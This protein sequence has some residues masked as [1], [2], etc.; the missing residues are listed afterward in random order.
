M[1]LSDKKQTILY[2]EDNCMIQMAMIS[3]IDRD[4][5]D[6]LIADN[7]SQALNYIFDDKLS[8]DV[9]LTDVDLGEGANGWEVARCAR[10]QKPD[11]P[12]IYTSSVDEAAWQ[13]NG[14]SASKLCRKPFRPSHV[15][16]AISALLAVPAESVFVPTIAPSPFVAR[17]R[18]AM[19]GACA[20]AVP[21]AVPALIAADRA[22]ADEG[23]RA[24][25]APWV[26]GPLGQKLFRK[27][28]PAPNG[29]WTAQRKAEVVAAV[30]GGLLSPDEL[31]DL[32]GLS[33]EEFASW[34]RAIGRFG[35]SALKQTR[36]QHYRELEQRT[37]RFGWAG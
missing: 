23:T 14:V 25:G 21:A 9:L 2:V 17:Y 34:Q 12:V 5:F 3:F 20:V 35:L 11:M 6:I 28:L 4:E 37:Q 32:Y 36:T 26:V 27:A 13:A 10:M 7:A 24:V 31:F 29:K 18:D 1:K 22:P 16:E 19:P 15:I 33:S 8:F 30:S